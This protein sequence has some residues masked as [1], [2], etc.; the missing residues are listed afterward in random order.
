MAIKRFCCVA[1]FLLFSVCLWTP[2]AN[3]ERIALVIGNAN[4]ENAKPLAKTAND[5]EDVAAMLGDLG[6]SLIGNKAHIDQSKSDIVRLVGDLQDAVTADD[7]V[8][9]Y[10]SGHGVSSSGTNYILPVDDA[11][12]R[13]REDVP[14]LAYSVGRLLARLPTGGDGS[15]IVILDAC[16]D[17][18]LPD[19]AKSAGASRGLARMDVSRPGTRILYA[20]SPNERAYE[21]EGRNGIFTTALL[22][23]LPRQGQRLVDLENAV[24]N[25]VSVA[26]LAAGVVQNPWSEGSLGKAFYFAPESL[27][28]A[29][30]REA[31]LELSRPS[32][33]LDVCD[34]YR[35]F[36]AD[37]P[38]GHFSDRVAVLLKN[39][40][41]SDDI[42][43][44]LA[45]FDDQMEAFHAIEVNDL[46]STSMEGPS[47]LPLAPP[48]TP[49][50]TLNQA[51][52]AY[53][54]YNS[55]DLTSGGRA[56]VEQAAENINAR[57][58]VCEHKKTLINFRFPD[59]PTLAEVILAQNR[60]VV[61]KEALSARGISAA[62]V[63]GGYGSFERRDERQ[64]LE[65]R[66]EVVMVAGAIR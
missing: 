55:S 42:R 35:Q 20:A 57:S 7:T 24:A 21:G 22:K 10:Y 18:P 47:G 41:C 36:L 34:A 43:D 59:N 6:Y 28:A 49:C 54:E 5:A 38:N 61:V 12:I 65:R 25:D 15:R 52:A 37:Y 32:R 39:P 56:V 23:H 17:N 31:Y 48:P 58:D 2:F 8:V 29:M 51:F 44:F 9:V 50:S 27:E 66:V 64:P 4:Y 30:E 11:G 53:F 14:D 45:T 46:K 63:F 19:G 13:V 40:P 60:L 26:A 33:D 62:L 16:R 1:S 3:A